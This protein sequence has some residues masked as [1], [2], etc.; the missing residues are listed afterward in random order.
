L[1]VNG[2]VQVSSFGLAPLDS[3]VVRDG[4]IQQPDELGDAIKNLFADRKLPRDVHLGI[5]NQQV[6]V[7][8][9]RLPRI[10]SND[11]LGAAVRFAAQAHIPMPL[12][13]AIMDWQ[14]VPTPPNPDGTP[15]ETIE[16]VAVAARREML[17]PAVEAVKR[18]GLRLVGIDHSAFALI[19]A[20][21]RPGA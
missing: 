1:R 2:G 20:L 12:D 11:E 16:V 9:L 10:G 13:R 14:V 15:S 4:E 19:R 17:A 5:A 21:S 6:A 7:R 18:A 3:G 8:T